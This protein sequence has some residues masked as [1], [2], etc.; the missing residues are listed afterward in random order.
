[1]KLVSTRSGPKN[2]SDPVHLTR[3]L[4]NSEKILNEFSAQNL[5][6]LGPEAKFWPDSKNCTQFSPTSALLCVA[7][8]EGL[9]HHSL[10]SPGPKLAQNDA[11]RQSRSDGRT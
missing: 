4:K 6:E 11:G 5:I 10:R 3:K 1:M 8:G 7:L 2:S 9:G